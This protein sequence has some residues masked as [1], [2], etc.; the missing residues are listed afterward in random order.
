MVGK[1]VVLF[2]KVSRPLIIQ[3]CMYRKKYS[4]DLANCCY[5][6]RTHRLLFANM[7]FQSLE[8]REYCVI[9]LF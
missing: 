9:A 4:N 7:M 2:E 6:I 5:Q 1:P 8:S 3:F